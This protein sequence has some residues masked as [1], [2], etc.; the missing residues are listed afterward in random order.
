MLSRLGF[1]ITQ[2]APDACL[3]ELFLFRNYSCAAILILFSVVPNPNMAHKHGTIPPYT[4]PLK[5]MKHIHNL[6][7][8]GTATCLEK[9]RT[10]GMLKRSNSPG[11]LTATLLATIFC[12][13]VSVRAATVNW[14]APSQD[15]YTNTA[16][17]S[18]GIVP[19]SA[20][21]AVIGN[22]TVTS[23]SVLFTNAS[24]FPLPT[25]S[26]T[27][28]LLG[29]SASSTGL[30][31]MNAGQFS[32]TNTGTTALIPGNAN[33]STGTFIMN[34]GTLNV[35]RNASTFFQDSFTPGNALNSSGTFTLN[36]GT[37]TFNCGIEIGINGIG[38][39]NVN[40]GTLIGNGWFGVA[41][42]NSATTPAQGNFNLSNGAVYILRNPGTDGGFHGIAFCQQGTNANVNISGGSLYC[43]CLRF[44]AA[45]VNGSRTTYETLNVS[46]GS[47]YLGGVGVANQAGAGTHNI[48]IN[49]SGG[50]FHTVDLGPN[51]GGTQGLASVGIDGTNWSWSSALP[52][53]LTT[54][55]GSGIVTFAPEA[56]RTITLNN[57]FSGSGALTMAGPGT[58]AING[59]N[60]YSGATTITGGTVIGTGS[61]QGAVSVSPAATI[62][63]GS[64]IAPGTLTLGSSL[65]LN[66]D[67]NIFRLSGNPNTVGSGV[68]DLLVVNGNVSLQGVSTI[69]IVPVAPLSVAA[70][71]TILQYSGTPLTTGDAAHLH[72]ISASPRYSFTVVD[73]ATTP[74]TI[75]ISVSGNAANLRWNGGVAASPTAWDN[76][77]TNWLN[78]GTS[79]LDLFY[80]G[81]ATT[82]ND[83]AAT[84]LVTIVGTQQPASILMANSSLPYTFTGGTL[85]LSG[86]LD[87]EGTGSLTLQ[88]SNAPNINAITANAGKM[89]FNFQGGGSFPIAAAISDNGGGQGTLVQAGS[90]TVVLQGDD[91]LFNGTMYVTNGVLQYTN[92]SGLG[93]AAS[94]LYV[95]NNGSVDLNGVYAGLKNFILAGNGYNGA[96][97]MINSSA[98]ALVNNNGVANISLAADT[99]VGAVNRWDSYQNSFHGNGFKLTCVGP[100]SVLLIDDGETSIGDIHVTAGRLGFQGNVTMGDPTKMAIVESNAILS[101]F[102]VSNSISTNGGSAK[103]LLL[104]NHCVLDSGGTS[105]NFN[106]NIFLAGTNNLFGTRGTLHLWGNIMDTN[107]PGGFVLGNDSVGASGG[108]LYIDGMNTYSGPTIISNRTLFVGANSSLG[109]SSLVSISSGA[110]LNTSALATF[111]LGSGQTLMGN[112]TLTANSVGFANGSTLRPGVAGTN[113]SSLTLSGSLTLQSGSTNVVVVNKTTSVAN[114]KVVGLA[115]VSIGGTLVISNVGNALAAGDA[116]QVFSSVG[117]YS[118]SFSQIIPATPNAGLVWDTSTLTSDGNVRVKSSG[119]PTNPTNL[120]YSFSAT[121]LTLSWPSNYIGWT[122]QAQTNPPGTGLTTNWYDV[123]GATNT[124][125]VV[126]PISGTNGSGFYRMILRH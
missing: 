19:A 118:G 17:W 31:T 38:T 60:N 110:T 44:A 77:T 115:S 64:T 70:P 66:A 6:L 9:T 63:P 11:G 93:A 54:S 69:M 34:G 74:G 107:G 86:T 126:I 92:A 120:I 49:V 41:R 85:S 25:N 33:P 45:N 113:T 58:L 23:G 1:S 50:T 48:T 42:G 3:G 15:Y 47:I 21:T 22:A 116:I 121:Q 122:L 35:V 16:A 36:G 32:I 7:S 111:Q 102:S 73:P 37:A 61:I 124:N 98:N 43:N 81:D 91:S 27:S 105:N 109:S 80:S 87:L 24:G 67:T 39:V 90:N 46:G 96:G 14:I 65:T 117:S 52:A 103:V 82:F 75:Q 53:N 123:P 83:S 76:V 13:A 108:D 99:A 40:G 10:F 55:P 29:N 71:Y 62:A 78:T 12:G 89:I 84:N 97:A 26:V 125:V 114:N 88:M 20:D 51:T 57:V 68:N 5:T 30:F 101:M 59:A 28:L 8:R 18:T 94:P 106:G 119:P 79:A 2:V 72:V 4:L 56:N 112:G 100:G 95:T 104:N